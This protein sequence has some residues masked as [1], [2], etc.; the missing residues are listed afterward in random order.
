MHK[1]WTI[2]E[3]LSRDKHSSLFEVV[4]KKVLRHQHQKKIYHVSKSFVLIA[5]VSLL[6]IPAGDNLIKHFMLVIY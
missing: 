3:R 2:L 4:K 5:A 1:K 6:N